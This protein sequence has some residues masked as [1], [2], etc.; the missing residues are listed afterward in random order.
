M[1][2]FIHFFLALTV[3]MAATV[4][5]GQG[6]SIPIL[7]SEYP[8]PLRYPVEYSNDGNHIHRLHKR[9]PINPF[10]IAKAGLIGGASCAI[11]PL[12]PILFLQWHFQAQLYLE[13]KQLSLA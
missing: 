7:S 1:G 10:K 4:N 5:M 11:P 2:K 8:I 9:S 6:A 13:L 12:C 3:T